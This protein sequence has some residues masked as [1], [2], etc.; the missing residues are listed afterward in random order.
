MKIKNMVLN[1][2]MVGLCFSLIWGICAFLMEVRDYHSMYDRREKDFLYAVQDKEYSHLWE[3][4][5]EMRITDKD[6]SKLEEYFAVADYYEAA[7]Y[8]KAYEENGEK[9][10]AEEKRQMMEEAQGKMGKYHYVA[11]QI[12]EELEIIQ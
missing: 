6:L 4:S 12:L 2:V 11:E 1:I 10:K 7:L 8:Y 5:N 3:I 9:V